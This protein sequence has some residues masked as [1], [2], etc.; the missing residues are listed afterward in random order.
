MIRHARKE[1]EGAVCRGANLR[2][3]A[4]GRIILAY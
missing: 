3:G 1:P 2:K 4:L